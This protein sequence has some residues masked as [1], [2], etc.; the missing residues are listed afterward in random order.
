MTN[1]YKV[2]DLKFYTVLIELK[3]NQFGILL[4]RSFPTAFQ[5]SC[6]QMRKCKDLLKLGLISIIDR[7]TTASNKS[8]RANSKRFQIKKK[9]KNEQ[10][11]L[12][13]DTALLQFVS[14]FDLGLT[15][16]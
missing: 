10:S 13:E 8:N 11:Q 7:S 5:L 2:A 9:V 14:R 1:R 12:L 15:S 6:H 3:T 4:P 16:I